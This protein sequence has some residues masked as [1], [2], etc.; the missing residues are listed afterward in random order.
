[1]AGKPYQARVVAFTGA[2]RGMQ[3]GYK[4]FFSQEL[5]ATKA[6]EN[7]QFKQLSATSANVTW[8]SL[9]LF[10][11][12]GFP[13]YTVT[14]E[15]VSRNSCKKRPTLTQITNN[16][17]IVFTNLVSGTI[18]TATVGSYLRNAN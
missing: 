6:L 4:T 15:P 7:V 16:S 17:F 12:R 1:M 9:T 13:V 14:I 2:G 18:N 5:S 10:E 3:N 11:A 8:T